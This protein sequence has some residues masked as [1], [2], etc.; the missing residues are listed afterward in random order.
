[1]QYLNIT[2]I[3]VVNLKRKK[4]TEAESTDS[5]EEGPASCR[6]S[7]DASS[8]CVQFGFTGRTAVSMTTHSQASVTLSAEPRS[9]FF[10]LLGF[11]FAAFLPFVF[12]LNWHSVIDLIVFGSFPID[13]T[14]HSKSSTSLV[15][16]S[17]L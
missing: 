17:V 10:F 6:D 12:Q 5:A 9:I 15:L 4:K 14:C 3:T 11:S 13:N 16:K 8:A 1:M 2:V 7:T